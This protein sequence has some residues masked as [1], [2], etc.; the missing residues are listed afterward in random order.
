MFVAHP[1]LNRGIRVPDRYSK[2]FGRVPRNV[3]PLD[4]PARYLA[5]RADGTTEWLPHNYLREDDER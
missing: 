4:I 5:V 3:V 2:R 1:T